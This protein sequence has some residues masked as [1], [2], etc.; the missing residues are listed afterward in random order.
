MR[1]IDCRIRGGDGTM[2]GNIKT[3]WS[4]MSR[5][6]GKGMEGLPHAKRQA[7]RKLPARRSDK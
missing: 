1:L 3:K 7:E 6:C 2:Q 5:A 4:A